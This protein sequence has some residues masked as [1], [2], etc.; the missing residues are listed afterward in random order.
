MKNKSWK[1]TYEE[2][3][4]KQRI[5]NLSRIC[6]SML[7]SNMFA[8]LLYNVIV[9]QIVEVFSFLTVLFGCLTIIFIIR[10]VHIF[11]ILQ[12]YV[13]SE[14]W[15]C[16]MLLCICLVTTFGFYIINLDIY[17]CVLAVMLIIFPLVFSPLILRKYN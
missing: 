17:L 13:K 2:K 11:L 14:L 10:T 3:I 7:L 4:K 12:A 6:N 15:L 1:L 16:F 8:L 9:N 5:R